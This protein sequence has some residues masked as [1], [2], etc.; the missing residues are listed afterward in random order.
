[1]KHK[2]PALVLAA[3]AFF[4]IGHTAPAFA[5]PV[6]TIV[7]DNGQFTIDEYDGGYYDVHN[8]SSNWYIYAFAVTNP[9]AST[10]NPDTS[11]TNWLAESTQL[12]LTGPNLQDVNAYYTQ[13]S[14]YLSGLQNLVLNT[15]TTSNYIGPG[16]SSSLFTFTGTIASDAGLLV[17]NS[18]GSEYGQF[19]TAA[20]TPLP[21]TLPLFVA[22]LSV[23]G[24]FGW[25][26]K[27]KGIAGLEIS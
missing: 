23:I 7:I 3:A 21:A 9:S 4:V 27:R 15:V 19:S 8:N 26:R 2:L 20:N 18:T 14:T 12:K 10:D 16:A 11:F 5:V 25:W 1:M 22:G 24:L 17:V 13:D 6:D